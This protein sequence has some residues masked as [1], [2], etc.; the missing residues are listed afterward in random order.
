MKRYVL[1]TALIFCLLMMQSTVYAKYN[2][3]LMKFGVKAGFNINSVANHEINTE[4]RTGYTVGATMKYAYTKTVSLQMEL[5]IFG[6]G[7]SI[8]QIIQTL[9]DGSGE[10]DTLSG[11]II[12]GQLEIPIIAR[13]ELNA[14]PK[15]K[16]YV[17]AGGF[18]SLAVD[19]KFRLSQSNGVSIDSDL[20][21]ASSADAGLLAGGG[22]DMKAGK[23]W[24]FLEIRYEMGMI[25]AVKNTD[26]KLRSISFTAGYWF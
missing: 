21:N 8:P 7:Y 22:I 18:L 23:G 5:L 4:S 3:D 15:Y 25:A 14:A 17:L 1:Y 13:F 12:I 10:T 20:D 26:Y 11:D 9:D 16:P 24:I 19:K 2:P 6:K